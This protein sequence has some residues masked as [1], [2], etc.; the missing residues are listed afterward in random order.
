MFCDT[1]GTNELKSLTDCASAY[2]LESTFLES[3]YYWPTDKI[4]TASDRTR[5]NVCYITFT[6][7]IACSSRK[8]LI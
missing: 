8:T 2:D 3:K 5:P 6:W 7:S 1:E 4:L